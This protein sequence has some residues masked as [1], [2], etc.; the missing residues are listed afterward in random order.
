MSELTASE[1]LLA[2][3][4]I[5]GI[6]VEGLN[7]ANNVYDRE[8]YTQ[9]LEIVASMYGAYLQAPEEA[10]L[11]RFREELGSC[12][13]KIGVNV[14]VHTTSGQL[15][16][17]RRSDDQSWCLPCGWVAIGEAAEEAAERETL[18]ETGLRV[19][20]Q[21]TIDLHMKG[22]QENKFLHHQLNVLL[23][24]AVIEEQ[25]VIVSEEHSE[26]DW[27]SKPEGKI[28]HPGHLEHAACALA[29]IERP[30]AMLQ[31]KKAS[32]C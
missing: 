5:R 19:R 23:I 1:I 32:D 28:W 9:L 4:K 17:L 8:R 26:Y 11:S 15:L 21:G 12:T 6:A 22:P 25:Q 20:V 7:Y 18:E 24:A 10:L 2:M 31:I 13:P 30:G 14:A 16:A 29:F 3:D 27:I